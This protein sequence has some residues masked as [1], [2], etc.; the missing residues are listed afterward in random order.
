MDALTLP[1]A[2]VGITEFV[3]RA[4]KELVG[5]EVSGVITIVVAVVV[6]ALLTFV[7]L[8]SEIIQNVYTAAVAVGGL[9]GIAKVA[10]AVKK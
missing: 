9:T 8:N 10:T 4:A 5:Y 1:L 3:K 7:D 2:I 6:A